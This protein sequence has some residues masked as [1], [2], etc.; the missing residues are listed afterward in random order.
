MKFTGQIKYPIGQCGFAYICLV[1]RN[2]IFSSDWQK[3]KSLI[4]VL[5]RMEKQAFSY[6]AVVNMKRYNLMENRNDLSK[7]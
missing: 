7:L 4:F 1:L 6:T 5:V 3:L 2:I